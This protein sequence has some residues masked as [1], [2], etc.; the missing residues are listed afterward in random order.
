MPAKAKG[1]ELFSIFVG[2]FVFLD[3]DP[4]IPLNPD[5]QHCGGTILVL[6]Q[7]TTSFSFLQAP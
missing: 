6:P 2:H 3:S 7:K 1:E 5:P 4:G